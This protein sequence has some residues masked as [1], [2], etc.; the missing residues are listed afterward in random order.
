ML[1]NYNNTKDTSESSN[2]SETSIIELN[3]SPNVISLGICLESRKNVRTKIK[4]NNSK[5]SPKKEVPKISQKE[6][7]IESEYGNQLNLSSKNKNIKNQK[8]SKGI[9]TKEEHEKFIEGVLMYGNEWVKVQEIIKTRTNYQAKSHAQ[10]FFEKY[11]DLIDELKN[12]DTINMI[13]EEQEKKI[14]DIISIILPDKKNLTQ[15]QKNKLLSAISSEIKFE[16]NYDY[17]NDDSELELGDNDN[18]KEKYLNNE[19]KEIYKN[20]VYSFDFSELN[21]TEKTNKLLGQKRKLSQNNE[22]KDKKLNKKKNESRRDSIDLTLDRVNQKEIG[23]DINYINDLFVVE[24]DLFI[25]NVHNKENM[26]INSF[27]DNK[28]IRNSQNSKNNYIFNNDINVTNIFK[29]NI[30]NKETINA[31]NFSQDFFLEKADQISNPK[32]QN[33]FGNFSSTE[34][35]SS[36]NS[37]NNVNNEVNNFNEGENDNYNRETDPFQLNFN[38]LISFSSDINNEN[39]R[40]ISLHENDLM[41]KDTFI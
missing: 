36:S 5:K 28:Q 27:I 3:N 25:K 26:M 32:N 21:P 22:S 31:N 11:K 33:F 35:N 10:K 37:I 7:N 38:S 9:W 39:E 4:K 16:E 40:Q 18:F 29:N 2:S 19:N 1:P 12:K 8:F 14:D 24:N 34:F 15:N 41:K 20:N 6:K 23:E 17:G 13:R 30:Y